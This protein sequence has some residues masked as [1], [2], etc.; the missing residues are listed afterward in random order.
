MLIRFQEKYELKDVLAQFQKD[1][2][3]KNYDL[4]LLDRYLWLL[5]K[6]YFPKNFKN[7]KKE[8]SEK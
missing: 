8:N 4:K 6:E 1:H 2:G 3:M 7:T 5:G